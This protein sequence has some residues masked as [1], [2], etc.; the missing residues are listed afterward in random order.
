MQQLTYLH[1]NTLEECLTALHQAEGTALPYAGG[2]DVMIHLR[3]R[4]EHMRKM[5]YLVDLSAVPELRGITLQDGMIHLG[6]MST[7]TEVATSGL[8]K[9]HAPFLPAAAATV[10][11]LQIRNAGTIGGTSA[12][13]PPRR[14]PS[15][16][17]PR[18]T[19]KRFSPASPARVRF[20]SRCSTGAAA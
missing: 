13:A 17:S 16:R 19:R 15:P 2:T 4:T 10:G 1:P 12:T 6:A 9:T 14:T 7:H 18:W 11:S 3:E 20:L 8:L 5:R